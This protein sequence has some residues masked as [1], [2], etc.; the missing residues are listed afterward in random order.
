MHRDSTSASW[1]KL[2]AQSKRIAPSDFSTL[3]KKKYDK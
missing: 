2:D 3:E 1:K